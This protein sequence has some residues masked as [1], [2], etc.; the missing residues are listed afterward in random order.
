MNTHDNDAL[1]LTVNA[2]SSSIKLAGFAVDNP[3]EKLY[4]A[5][6]SNIGQA[7]ARF[8]TDDQAEPIDAKDHTTA[9]T[10]LLHWL[11]TRISA[12]QVVAVGHRVVHGGPEYHEAQLV[13]SGLL[14]DLQKLTAFDPA[15]L[16]VELQLIETFQ[17]L[18]PS[19]QQI[20][21]FDTAFHH[22]LPTRARLLPVP[23]RL[24][25]QGVRRYGF[26]GLSYAYI[27][28]ELRRIEGAAAANGK[29][30]IA[31]IGSGAS[32]TALHGGTSIDTTMSMTPA[33]GVP[34]S[35][36][37]GDLDP[38]LLLYL[39]R[40]QGYDIDQYNHMVNAE[41]GLLGLSETTADMEKLLEIEPTDERAKDAIDIFCYQ[42]KKSIGSLAAALGGLNTLVFTGGMG[43]NAPKIRTRVCENL[44]FLGV[45]LDATRNQEGARL[46]SADGS[47]V[48]VH[49]IRTDEAI[50]IAR[51]TAQLIDKRKTRNGL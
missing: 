14:A 19:T 35:T 49:V 28:Q 7:T 37:S 3:A 34:M 25:A 39:V 12:A 33:S 44:A 48:G 16:P 46:I 13:T 47:P 24:E 4:E 42:V 9:V 15:H 17:Q 32:L 38:G 21:C 31:H 27:L 26:H 30:I 10:A 50:T 20:V 1:L 2:G 51:E 6:I 5:T 23:R 41:S 8:V 36:R 18:L 45:H 11:M 40:T 43:E 22:D 29:V